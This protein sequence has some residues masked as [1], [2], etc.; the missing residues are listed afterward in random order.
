MGIVYLA[1]N[2]SSGKSY[3]GKTTQGLTRRKSQHRH[4]AEKKLRRSHFH[5]AIRKYGWDSFRWAVIA[6]C[7][8]H[9]GLFFAEQF[10]IKQL[11]TFNN[12]YNLSEGGQ[13]AVGHKQSA[14]TVA[15][16]VS[17]RAGYRHSEETKRRLSI[18]AKN[19]STIARKAIS[20]RVMKWQKNNRKAVLKQIETLAKLNQG[21]KHTE[22]AKLNMKKADADRP[23]MS[24]AT[25]R[26][27]SIANSKP[28][29]PL[30]EATKRKLA[31]TTA[32]SWKRGHL[33]EAGRKK[34][35]ECGH[36]TAA[37]MTAKAAE[38]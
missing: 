38:K 36:K 22:E 35:Q 9:K 17:G 33:T 31:V 18:A 29:G 32:N 21:R 7:E 28:H 13:G 15:K 1:W 12:G 3:V 8:C 19:R 2:M 5:A 24:E 30:S 26:K 23:P 27:L 11:G 37:I 25:K 16:K 6:R 34:L 20:Q 4:Q 14:E 10:L